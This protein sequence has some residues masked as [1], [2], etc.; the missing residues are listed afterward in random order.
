MEAEKVKKA[1]DSNL[2]RISSALIGFPLVVLICIIGNKYAISASLAIIAI[3][4]M[5]EYLHAV[6]KKSNPIKWVSY[7][8][9][10]LISLI[11]FIPQEQYGNVIMAAIPILVL[12]LFLQ[13]IVTGMKTNFNDLVYT[14][15]GIIYIVFFIGSMAMIRGLENGKILIWYV[16]WAGWATDVFA[17]AIGRRF[18]KH[19]FSSVSPKKSIEGCIAG[20][21]SAIIVSLVY[22]YFINT[23]TTIEYSYLYIGGISLVLSLVGQVGD[24]AASS[25]KRYVEIKDYSD[26]IP[27]HGGM[28]DRID[29]IMFIAP[30]AYM[31]LRL[32]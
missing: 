5:R 9:C 11:A 13:V 15:M 24:F 30:F 16:F 26:L 19:K 28:L 6:S 23:Y 2:K 27:G 20:T 10:V 7:L 29:S 25:I 1:G 31:L 32:L 22:T 21:I 14:F 12:L 17:Y 8:S 4:S 18:G 3:L